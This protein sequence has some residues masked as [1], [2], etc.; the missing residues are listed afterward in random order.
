MYRI[1]PIAKKIMLKIM[2]VSI[3]LIAVGTGLQAGKV[4]CLNLDYFEVIGLKPHCDF[5]FFFAATN[6]LQLHLSLSRLI[7]H[8]YLITLSFLD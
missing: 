3:V 6:L 8:C 2:K 4:Y 7:N 1:T 5:Y